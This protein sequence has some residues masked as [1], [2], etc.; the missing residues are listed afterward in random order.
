[1]SRSRSYPFRT[2]SGDVKIMT[3]QEAVSH[4]E[5]PEIKKKFDSI[6]INSKNVR[7]KK[8]GFTP[9]WQENIQA[10]AGGPQEY[11]R[12]LKEHGLIEIGYDYVPQESKGN[13][14]FCQSEEFVQACIEQGIDLTGNEVEAIKS[15]D[16]FKDTTAE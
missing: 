9:G 11:S 3:L 16:Y 14:N 15:G 8:D 1:M 5:D 2:S 12:L 7:R 13:H 4:L 6:L 10:Y